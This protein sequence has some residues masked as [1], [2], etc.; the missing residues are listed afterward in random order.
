MN[1][2]ADERGQKKSGAHLEQLEGR[3][4]GKRV[5]YGGIPLV[6]EL[7]LRHRVIL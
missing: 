3:A 4:R 6:H 2:T 5:A 7:V 1:E